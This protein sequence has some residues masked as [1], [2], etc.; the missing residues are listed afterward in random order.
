[1]KNVQ[2]GE[3]LGGLGTSTALCRLVVMVV[4]VSPALMFF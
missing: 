4:A 2:R 1:M 3:A